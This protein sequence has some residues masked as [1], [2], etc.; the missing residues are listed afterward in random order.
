MCR[1]ATKPRAAS[2]G[3]RPADG[4]PRLSADGSPRLSEEPPGRRSAPVNRRSA[5]SGPPAT[6]RTTLSRYS[7]RCSGSWSVRD[8]TGTSPR[9]GWYPSK[10]HSSTPSPRVSPGRS[11]SASAVPTVSPVLMSP[12]PHSCPIRPAPMASRRGAS[13][14]SKTLIA[15][16]LAASGRGAPGPWNGSGSRVRTVP[17]NIRTYAIFSPAG[18]RSTL[19][20]VPDTGPS[21]APPAVGSSSVR[22]AI[23]ASR[24]A[25][26]A[27]EPKNTGYTSPR[28]VCSASS[29]R[30]R[31]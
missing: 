29:P 22:P 18:P 4:S 10:A 1:C 13:P 24:P 28:F 9:T 16:T 14:C 19:K 31:S 17:E 27:A 20:T 12:S 8:R 21:A 7:F 30:S 6:R 26:V 25:P 2:R 11:A 15:L 3:R 23:S 5:P